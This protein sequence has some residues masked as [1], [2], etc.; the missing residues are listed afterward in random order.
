MSRAAGS[1]AKEIPHQRHLDALFNRNGESCHGLYDET[2]GG[3]PSRTRRNIDGLVARLNRHDIHN[4]LETN[5]ICYSTA[6]SADLSTQ[7]HAGGAGKEEEIFR[8]LLSEIAPIVL[9]VHGVRSVERISTILKINRLK[10]PRSA[11]EIHDVQTEQHLI[12]PIP[13]LAP[14]GFNKWSSWSDGYLDKVANC[15]QGKLAAQC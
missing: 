4:I 9:V 7:A 14:P 15:V 8:C 1:W 13:S 5:V 12:I 10:A 11:D 3:K 6:M 2:T